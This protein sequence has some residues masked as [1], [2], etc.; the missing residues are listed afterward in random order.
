MEVKEEQM[1]QV[2]GAATGKPGKEKKPVNVK[3]EIL[4]WILTI[5]VAVAAA[6]LIRTFLFEPIRVDGESMCDTLQNGE[7]MLVTKPEYLTGDPQRG[8]VVICKYPGRT[9]NFVKR[10]MGIPG[11]VIEIR[12]NVVYRNGEALDEPY[13]TPERNDNGFSMA[14]FTLG[15]DEYFVMGD[16]RDNSHDSRNYYPNSYPPTPAALTRDMIIGHVRCVIFPFNSI[17]TIE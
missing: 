15:E 2:E 4:S 14:P 5:A 16:N 13:L 8:D 11:D 7:I 1:T 6:L 12:S 3:K 17:R 9:E 10:V